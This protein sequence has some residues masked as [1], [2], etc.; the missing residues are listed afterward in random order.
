[1]TTIEMANK[2][3]TIK[4][5]E[6][7]IAEAQQEAEAIKDE[8]KAEMTAQ[9]VDEIAVDIFKVRYKVVTSSRFDSKS[10]KSKYADLFNEYS[11]TTE[12]RRFSIS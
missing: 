11:K 4:E 2:V 1:M 7:L 12:S 9:G 6:A 8:I 5:L 3:K 10:F